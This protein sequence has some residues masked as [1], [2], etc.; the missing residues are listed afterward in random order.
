MRIVALLALRNE[1]FYLKRC[2]EHLN[3]QGIETCIIDNNSN[4]GT[5]AIAREFIGRG[6][7][8]IERYPYPGFYD[9][10]GILKLK[11]T[12]SRATRADW[13]IHHDVD[14]IMEAPC[15]FATIADAIAKVD[16]EGFNTINFDEFVFVPTSDSESYEGQDYVANMRRYYFFEPTPLRLFRAWKRQPEIL[17]ASSGGHNLTFAGQKLY[18][19]NFVLR[20]YIGLSAAHLRAKYCGRSFSKNE[21]EERGWHGWRA[22]FRHDMLVL[23]NPTELKTLSTPP[24][25]DKSDPKTRHLFVRPDSDAP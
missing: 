14:E 11:E 25:W 24:E 15:Q 8:Q 20:H 19:Q 23:P 17:L 22:R 6:V 21:V 12:L 5:T 3:Q 13:F 2:L 9:W 18:P 7:I 10:W 16:A 4:D 1:D